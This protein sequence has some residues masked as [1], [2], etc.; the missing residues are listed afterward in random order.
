LQALHLKLLCNSKFLKAKHV[1]FVS[2]CVLSIYLDETVDLQNSQTTFILLLKNCLNY[3]SN[4]FG[5]IALFFQRFWK[6]HIIFPKFL[7]K[8]QNFSKILK[9]FQKFSRFFKNSQDFSK[10]FQKL[11]KFLLF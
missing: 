10:I 2:R 8:F 11:Q 5:K 9:I 3:F 4:G 1:L 7:E 6:N